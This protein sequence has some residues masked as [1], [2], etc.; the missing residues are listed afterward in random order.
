MISDPPLR[1]KYIPCFY[2]DTL[3]S[4]HETHSSHSA[5]VSPSCS[6]GSVR[7][8]DCSDHCVALNP[9]RLDELPLAGS[10]LEGQR[11]LVSLLVILLTNNFKPIRQMT[12]RVILSLQ[13]PG[14]V[15][16]LKRIEYGFGYIIVRSPYIPY[17]IYLRG[18]ITPKP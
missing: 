8:L 2:M 13:L 6:P 7:F 10:Y 15:V 5:A 16:P 12:T 11:G 4:R 3:G 18:T 14:F 17:S 9:T 1:P